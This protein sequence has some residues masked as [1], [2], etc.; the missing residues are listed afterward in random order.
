M[1]LTC[2]GCNP[3]T[4]EVCRNKDFLPGERIMKR[5]WRDKSFR[6]KTPVMVCI[7]CGWHCLGTDEQY[8]EVIRRTKKAYNEQLKSKKKS[9]P[10]LV[11]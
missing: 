10:K 7:E 4:F 8:K 5:Y 11:V 1:K 6:V 9:T 2:Y 3:T